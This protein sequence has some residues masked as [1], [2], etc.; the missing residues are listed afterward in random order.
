MQRRFSKR[1]PASCRLLASRRHR[2][3]AE[4]LKDFTAEAFFS[5]QA[6][7]EHSARRLLEETVDAIDEM[8]RAR[9]EDP[10]GSDIQ[11]CME[12]EHDSYAVEEA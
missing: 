1:L 12:A 5:I 4:E 9:A 8:L 11:L 10:P 7:S 2:A 6:P 3:T